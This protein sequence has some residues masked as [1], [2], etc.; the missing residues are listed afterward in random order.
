MA[1]CRRA[2]LSRSAR[3]FVPLLIYLTTFTV[4]LIVVCRYYLLPAMQIAATAT[5]EQRRFLAANARL[6]LTL[7]LIILLA[8]LLIALRSADFLRRRFS[9]AR[10]PTVYPDAWSESAPRQKTPPEDQ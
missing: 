6:L 9:G 5:P 4:L 7:L 1:A 3:S 8:M 10:K 2:P